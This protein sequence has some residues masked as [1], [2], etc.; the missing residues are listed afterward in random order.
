MGIG[1]ALGALVFGAAAAF[2]G[3]ELYLFGLTLGLW[4]AVSL[5]LTLGSLFDMP[6]FS[7]TMPSPNYTLNPITNTTAQAIPVPVVYGRTRVAG[8]VFYQQF[9]TSER[10]IMYQ[11]VGLSEGPIHGV[12]TS[13]IMVNDQTTATLST[14]TKYVYLG[15]ADQSASPYDPLGVTYPYTAYVSLRMEASEKLRG[16]PVVTA[17]INGRDIDYP[18]KG[19][20]PDNVAY[21]TAETEASSGN[22]LD[23][24]YFPD[25]AGYKSGSLVADA[26]GNY[27]GKSYWNMSI[28][29]A[30][31][32][33]VNKPQIVCVPATIDSQDWQTQQLRFWAY[34]DS[35]NSNKTYIFEFDGSTGR[36]FAKD[37]SRLSGDGV[38]MHWE[39]RRTYY[40]SPNT[41]YSG[42][43][44]FYL[45]ASVLPSNGRGK[46]KFELFYHKQTKSNFYSFL[47]L[48]YTDILTDYPWTGFQNIIGISNPAWCAYDFLT[49]TR[50]GAGL[51]PEYFDLDSFIEVGAQCNAEL[52]MLNLVIDTQRP[53]AD[54]LKDIL[55]P[56][57]AFLVARDKIRIRMDAPVVAPLRSIQQSDIIEGSFSYGTTPADQIPNRVTVEYIDGDEGGEVQP[58][59]EQ[60]SYSVED[61]DDIAE[62]GVFER[63]VSVLGITRK[64]Q[65]KAMANYLF[66]QARRC[67]TYCTFA[68]ALN[69]SDVEV[70]DVV[71]ITHD[72]PGWQEKW[73]RV[74]GVE[75][76]P[77]CTVAIK[78]I[79]Y[80]PV[81]YD[82]SD[83]V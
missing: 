29:T 82:T 46:L 27:N 20:T 51:P 4:Q 38:K 34:P 43:L 80:D 35:N 75:D 13:D 44:Y 77:D 6:S 9:E 31:Y 15:T 68:A 2:A 61:W 3:G 5:G 45:P 23:E 32:S 12:N 14:L 60:T 8:N 55:A 49:N 65:A 30:T 47:L 17:V 78:C 56:A 59:W 71:A 10:K 66:E 58:T 7:S 74:I 25:G 37:F 22:F 72:L 42:V 18:G 79:E 70:G 57:R 64:A 21:I 19:T 54:I 24:K 67:R 48:P 53:V 40:S 69:L 76:G 62:R 16:T 63:R 52:L 28:L 41:Y 1:A 83:D 26:L 36:D 81:V 39:L 50:Y 33:D 73:M 11:H